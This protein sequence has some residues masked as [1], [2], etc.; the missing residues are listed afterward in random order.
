MALAMDIM[1]GH[2][3]SS[4]MRL[5]KRLRLAINYFAVKGVLCTVCY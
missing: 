3:P 5:Q 4:E 2:G 1:H